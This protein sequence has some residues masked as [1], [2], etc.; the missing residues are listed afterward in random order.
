[1]DWSE[2]KD[3]KSVP[4]FGSFKLPVDAPEAARDSETSGVSSS[5]HRSHRHRSRSPHEQRKSWRQHDSVESPRSQSSERRHRF[6]HRD[7]RATRDLGV[8]PRRVLP[9]KPIFNEERTT[10]D[11]SNPRPFSPDNSPS[12]LSDNIIYDSKGDRSVLKYGTAHRYDIP[13]YT[14]VGSGQVMGLPAYLIIERDIQDKDII[15][16]RD[17]RHRYEDKKAP[18]TFSQHLK[19]VSDIYRFRDEPVFA[20]DESLSHDFLSLGPW[21]NT[22]YEKGEVSKNDNSESLSD[23]DRQAYRSILGKAKYEKKVPEGMEYVSTQDSQPGNLHV[24]VDARR[25]SQHAELR[26]VVDSHPTDI[27]AWLNLVRL[28]TILHGPEDESRSLTPA[29]EKA[30]ADVKLGLLE[31]ALKRS[32]RAVGRDLLLMERLKEGGKLWDRKKLLQEWKDTVRKLPNSTDLLLG[33]LNFRQR[34]SSEFSL[35]EHKFL[36][37]SFMKQAASELDSFHQNQVQCYLL[38]RLS[39]LLIEAGYSELASGLW[40]AA[41][42]FVFF[43]PPTLDKAAQGTALDAFCHFWDSEVARLGE[44]KESCWETGKQIRLDPVCVEFDTGTESSSLFESWVKTER[45]VAHALNMPA[46]SVD[47]FGVTVDTTF[48]VVLSSDIREVLPFVSRVDDPTLLINAFLCFCRLPHLTVTGNYRTTRSWCGDSFLSNTLEDFVEADFL[49]WAMD[50]AN[51]AAHHRSPLLFPIID[52]IHTP[53]TLFAP[54]NWFYSMRP[55][56]NARDDTF[57]LRQGW[58]RQ[59]LRKLVEKFDQNCDLAEYALAL[60]FVCDKETANKY[61]K[62]LLRSRPSSL[63]L[64]NAFALMQWRSGSQ[65]RALVTWSSAIKERKSFADVEQ[66]DCVLLW[67]AWIWELLDQ[68][69]LARPSYLLNAMAQDEIDMAVYSATTDFVEYKALEKLKQERFCHQFCQ[70]ALAQR[71]TRAFVA[72]ADCLALSRYLSEKSLEPALAVYKWAMLQASNNARLGE[73]DFKAFT[74]EL[75]HQSRAKLVFFHTNRKGCHMNVH[76]LQSILKESVVAFPHNTI[77][78]SLFVWNESRL[79]ITHRVPDPIGFVK[80]GSEERHLREALSDSPPAILQRTNVTLHLLSVYS[81]LWR[82][83]SLNG[84]VHAVRAA[85]E[86]ALWDHTSPIHYRQGHRDLSGLADENDGRANITLW[87]LYLLFELEGPK[88]TKAAK[89]VLYRA[90]RACPWSKELVLLG[91]ERLGNTSVSNADSLHFNDMRELYNLLVEKQLRIRN[92]ISADLAEWDDQSARAKREA[93][94]WFD[95]V[96]EELGGIEAGAK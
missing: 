33:Y 78:L 93:N 15:V 70:D 43:A 61:A 59:T 17:K 13:S 41:L 5:K 74:L 34:D 75:L 87:K 1:M 64:Y 58:V 95:A 91:M 57:R 20:S 79:P 45:K 9:S 31:E 76:Q 69:D 81:A 67:N 16:L 46:R 21:V 56:I 11:T 68:G 2:S 86:K 25:R 4:K 82:F 3:K 71:H 92:D 7:G 40:Q 89:D 26:R 80:A 38:L 28:Q 44:G 30:V 49:N 60:E 47:D 12:S 48:S 65:D 29:E 10:F 19:R 85:F 72:S 23:D 37:I 32:G 84:S 39:L 51:G 66:F 62:R 88:D 77:F 6:S 54:P 24:A 53:D 52:F 50:L 73:S 55:W 22:D 96:V 14:R 42:E 8:K 63:R 18:G 36:V 83:K 27:A 35:D 94:A 90:I